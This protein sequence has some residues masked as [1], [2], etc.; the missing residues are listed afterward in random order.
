MD[1]LKKSFEF[2]KKDIE[3]FTIQDVK[4]LQKIIEYHS[5]LYYNKQEP[6]ISD[7]EYD[8]LFKKLELLEEKYKDSLDY[9]QTRE[10]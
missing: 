8:E 2:L 9:F 5:D 3:L 7:K 10:V 1:K 6:I 4:Q